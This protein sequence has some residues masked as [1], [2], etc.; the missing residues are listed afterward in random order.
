MGQG[1]SDVCVPL[2]HLTR[3]VCQ[4]WGQGRAVSVSE[5]VQGTCQKLALIIQTPAAHLNV[6]DL[7]S[8][9]DS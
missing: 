1:V 4:I 9:C 2:T 7:A 6:S 5:W 3:E 8:D